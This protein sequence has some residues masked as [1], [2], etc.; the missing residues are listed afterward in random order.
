MHLIRMQF[1]AKNALGTELLVW[2]ERELERAGNG[3]ILLTGSAGA[4][5]AGLDLREVASHDA[6]GMERF[7]RLMDDVSARLY[8]HPAPTVAFVNG[9]AIAGGAVL[10][11][12]CDWRIAGVDPR[13]KI[14]V[15]EVAI[16]ACFPP[17]ILRILMERLPAF[18]REQVLLGAALHPPE[19]ALALGLVDE[20]SSTGEETALERL[21]LL[22]AHPRAT[23]AATKR[24]MRADVTQVTPAEERSFCEQSVPLWASEEMKQRVLAVLAR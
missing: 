23:Y 12:C 15:N 2:L 8:N 1:P 16:G 3:P 5:S 21:R 17:K 9:H 24:A 19:R 11:C 13:V 4:F 7:L 22:S 10:A 20:L 14:G 18:A 6:A